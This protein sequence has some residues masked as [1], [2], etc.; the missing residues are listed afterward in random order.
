MTIRLTSSVFSNE[1][2]IPVDY[3]CDGKNMS[4]PLMW[5]NL[6]STTKSLAITLDDPDAPSGIFV[7]WLLYNQPAQ[8]NNLPLDIPATDTLPNGARQGANSYGNV[9][10]GGPCPPHGAT[11]RY[12]FKIYALD[13][14]LDLE[15]GAVRRMLISAMDG[16]ILDEGE[17]V[18]V[19]SRK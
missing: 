11:H 12:I 14:V 5:Q 8:T 17:L 13:V 7:H 4:P 6:P 9:G 16:H 18:G 15:P 19:Y 2:S 10:Y 1:A 3:T